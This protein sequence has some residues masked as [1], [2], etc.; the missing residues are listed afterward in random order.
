MI[1]KDEKCQ[2]D[3][4]SVLSKHRNRNDKSGLGYFKI[5]KPSS[6]KTNFVKSR[7]AYNNFKTKKVLD[8][9]KPKVTYGRNN[10]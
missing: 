6:S 2:L 9:F 8:K 4:K 3:L 10:F 1:K 5:Y 7:D